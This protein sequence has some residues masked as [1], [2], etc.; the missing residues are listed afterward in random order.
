MI[1][2]IKQAAV[3]AV[4]QRSPMNIAYGTVTKTNPLEINVDQRMPISSE[5]LLLTSNVINKEI[6]F[7]IEDKTEENNLHIHEY[8]GQKKCT[9]LNELKVGEEVLLLRVQG[10]QKY[11]VLDRLVSE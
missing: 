10:G 5:M 2:I 1:Q 11:I 7:E 8:K 6:E 9:V 3:D 4:D